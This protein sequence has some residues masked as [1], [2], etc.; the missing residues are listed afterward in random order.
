MHLDA[1]KHN[2]SLWDDG[3]NIYRKDPSPESD[4]AWT[5]LSKIPPVLISENDMKQL[6]LSTEGAVRWPDDPTGKTY[7]AQLDIFHLV[8]CVD[9]LRRGV[10]FKH[11]L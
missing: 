10:F 6:G 5:S 3:T 2:S 8:H 1:V 7:V 9:A 11:Y 4:E